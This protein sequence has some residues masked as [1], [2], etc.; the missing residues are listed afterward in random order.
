MSGACHI[1]NLIIYNICWLLSVVQL[2]TYANLNPYLKSEYKETV[3][4]CFNKF[5][6]SSSWMVKYMFP[7]FS[8]MQ[9]QTCYMQI[10]ICIILLIYQQITIFY[11]G[12]SSH[13]YGWMLWCLVQYNY[14][15]KRYQRAVAPIELVRILRTTY[16]MTYTKY[17]YVR[18]SLY[19][20]H[21]GPYGM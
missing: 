1:K 4:R 12:M 20:S 21:D 6:F 16:N 2:D 17:L 14:L 19:F 9:I 18:F 11:K 15:L 10:Q 8:F 5:S 3:L 13:S 7:T